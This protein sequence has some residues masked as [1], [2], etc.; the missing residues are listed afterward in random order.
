MIIEVFAHDLHMYI[1]MDG[2]GVSV[3]KLHCRFNQLVQGCCNSN[4][5]QYVRSWSHGPLLLPM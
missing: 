5:Q 2:K 3:P 1:A 4:P